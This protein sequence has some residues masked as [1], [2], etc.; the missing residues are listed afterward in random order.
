MVVMAGP[1]EERLSWFFNKQ[2]MALRAA[3]GYA[4]SMGC[5]GE[6]RVS[7]FLFVV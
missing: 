2:L 6:E 5:E 3:R 7:D 4:W 1:L